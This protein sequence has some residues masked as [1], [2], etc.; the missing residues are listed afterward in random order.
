MDKPHF[1]FTKIV[2][3]CLFNL[4]LHISPSQ[5]KEVSLEEKLKLKNFQF[6]T[7]LFSQK[8]YFRTITECERYLS[9][10]PDDAL[11]EELSYLIGLSYFKSGHYLESIKSFNDFMVSFP[12]GKFKEEAQ[13]TIGESYFKDKQYDIATHELKRYLDNFPS[14]KNEKKIYLFLIESNL[15]EKEWARANQY[16]NEYLEKYEETEYKEDLLEIKELNKETHKFKEKSPLLAS[17]LSAVLPG[18]GQ[19][20]CKRYG[21][22]FWSFLLTGMLISQTIYSWDN[23]SRVATVIWGNF[24]LAFYIGGIY[25]ARNAALNYKTKKEFEHLD[26]LRRHYPIRISL[27]LEKNVAKNLKITSNFQF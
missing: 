24:A 20:Y 19:L 13:A 18:S 12:E 8:Q 22:A 27:N 1:F 10:Y 26:N 15:E 14:G 21:D 5:A 23:D 11:A 17:V 6:I 2:L 7:F 9:Y 25:G 16:I 4:F 3:L